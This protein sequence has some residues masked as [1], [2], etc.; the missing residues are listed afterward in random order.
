ME[1]NLKEYIICSTIRKGGHKWGKVYYASMKD[2]N[3]CEYE[4]F[5]KLCGKVERWKS[6]LKEE[7]KET[8]VGCIEITN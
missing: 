1:I 6:N 4:K 5:C 3:T 7:T 8:N 2:S